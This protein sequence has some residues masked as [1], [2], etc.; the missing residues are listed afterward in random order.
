MSIF[1]KLRRTIISEGSVYKASDLFQIKEEIYFE[2]EPLRYA[3]RDFLKSGE[4]PTYYKLLGG[5]KKWDIKE[6][7]VEELELMS[8]S[9]EP[10]EDELIPTH[11]KTLDPEDIKKDDITL[12]NYCKLYNTYQNSN[13]KDKY[14]NDLSTVFWFVR[15][16]EKDNRVK[17]HNLIRIINDAEDPEGSINILSDK[18]KEDLNDQYGDKAGNIKKVLKK[19]KGKQKLSKETLIQLLKSAKHSAYK[20]YEDS[21]VGQFFSRYGKIYK[22]KYKEA[23]EEEDIKNLLLKTYYEL[24]TEKGRKKSNV[25]FDEIIDTYAN[26]LVLA[27][28]EIYKPEEVAKADLKANKDILDINGKVVIPKDGLAEVK[29]R[30]YT[31]PSYLSEYFSIYKRPN[32]LYKFNP[33]FKSGTMKNLYNKF[34]SNVFDKFKEL[35]IGDNIIEEIRKNT[36]GIFFGEKQLEGNMVPLYVPLDNID[37]WWAEE[38]KKDPTKEKRL[39]IRYQIKNPNKFYYYNRENSTMIPNTLVESY[40]LNEVSNL[41]LEGRKEDILKKYGGMDDMA[42]D[43]IHYFSNNDPSG[44][45][46]YLEWMTKTWLGLIDKDYSPEDNEVVDVVKLFHKNIQ[47]IERKDINSYTFKELKETVKEAEEKRELAQLKKEAKKQKTIIYEDDKWFVVS[48]HSWKASCYYGAGTKWCVT[49]KDTSRHWERYSRNASFFYVI[50]KNLKKNDPLYKVAYRVI[51]RKG[52]YELWDAEDLEMSR[53]PRGKEWF[54]SLPPEII[55]RAESY[56]EEKYPEGERPDWLDDD[57]RAQAIVNHLNNSNIERVDDY[58]R[59][60]YMYEVDD[61]YWVSAESEEMDDALY[62][63][64]NEYDDDD[65]IE[66]YDYEG[67]YLYMS[68]E[69]DFIDGEVEYTISDVHDDDFLEWTGLDSDWQKIEDKLEDLRSQLEDLDYEENE[70]EYDELES[71]ISDLET[72]QED[73]IENAKEKYAD[74]I[75]DDWERCLSDGPV[76]C[77]VREKGWYSNVQELYRSGA[78]ELDRDELINVLSQDGDYDSIVGDY[79]YDTAEDDEGDEF[80]VFQVDY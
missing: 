63:Y 72:E 78:V 32:D 54:K 18:I 52:K 30:D 37:L 28:K 17:F 56:H 27:I 79:G 48:P 21:F 39:T 57:F 4:I 11:L 71:E 77:L 22:I 65:L 62:D 68:N 9:Y 74:S 60:M 5:G 10:A 43:T 6:K 59:G 8:K 41:L 34:I 12:N 26:K 75:R 44:N 67:Y 38:G 1:S 61:E 35:P 47:R 69:S 80:Y 49:S 33:A 29:M 16:N 15:P 13:N 53:Q 36:F 76:E 14:I 19:L 58:W 64:Y 24:F 50:N 23:L 31:K 55:E 42:E 73:L 3:D 66:Y 2:P 70:E 51:G 40:N 45:N 46:K 20:N 25:N 7:C